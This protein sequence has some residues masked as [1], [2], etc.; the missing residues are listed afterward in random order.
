MEIGAFY[1][2]GSNRIKVEIYSEPSTVTVNL[3]NSNVCESS[4]SILDP[5]PK[6]L[7]KFIDRSILVEAHHFTDNHA[8]VYFNF[9]DYDVSSYMIEAIQG[10]ESKLCNVNTIEV[11]NSKEQP[12]LEDHLSDIQNVE[13]TD[14]EGEMFNE[15]P[16]DPIVS[17]D[18]TLDNIVMKGDAEVTYEGGGNRYLVNDE[19]ILVHQVQ[20]CSSINDRY[21]PFQLNTTIKCE[22]EATNLFS[23]FEYDQSFIKEVKTQ[24]QTGLFANY[25]TSAQKTKIE[26]YYDLNVLA[27]THC[28]S[29][30]MAS[31]VTTKCTLSINS[32][33]KEVEVT[34]EY[35]MFYVT[36]SCIDSTRFKIVCE[37]P[38]AK[39]F[40][41]LPQIELGNYPT[42]R[43]DIGKTRLADKIV[44]NTDEC[45]CVF[46]PEGSDKDIVG[47]FVNVKFVSGRE[48]SNDNAIID[49]RNDDNEGLLIYQETTGSIIATFG[50]GYTARSLPVIMEE[51]ETYE[52]KVQWDMDNIGIQVNDEDPIVIS[53]PEIP[54]PQDYPTRIKVG[55][56]ETL[57]SLNGDI[58]S[59]QIGQ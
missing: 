27:G 11:E 39:L 6:Q 41:L 43:I 36:G 28:F 7:A 50:E 58:V 32:L 30:L 51:G 40:V 3:L 53:C 24:V 48:F 33:E 18:F 31:N 42:S 19:G 2:E 22:N 49:W 17:I 12:Y 54:M 5:S 16:G 38:L 34:P 21:S 46:D 37:N 59:L 52:I 47:G 8:T 45:D 35:S 10:E 55:Y 29:V 14:I 15:I 57:N 44:V 56:S 23:K 9:L 4:S 1:T 20:A 25:Y 26:L 13:P